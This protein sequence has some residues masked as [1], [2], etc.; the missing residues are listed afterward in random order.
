MKVR[1]CFLL[2][3]GFGPIGA[4]HQIAVIF[5]SI[6]DERCGVL[7]DE[8]LLGRKDEQSTLSERRPIAGK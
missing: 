8:K 1:H 7:E 4:S 2:S 5:V 6:L 3:L